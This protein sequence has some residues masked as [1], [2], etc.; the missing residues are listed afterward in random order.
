MSNNKTCWYPV[1]S[2][3]LYEAIPY[4]NNKWLENKEW[5]FDN[6]DD[7]QALC[8]KLNKEIED[9]II[10]IAKRCFNN[11]CGIESKF[12]IDKRFIIPRFLSELKNIELGENNK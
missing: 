10:R 12:N 8:D 4:E 2:R 3:G 7:C 11:I 6:E 1:K 9:E 5:I